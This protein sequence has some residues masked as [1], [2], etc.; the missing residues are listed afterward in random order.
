MVFQNYALYPHMTVARNMSF[1][2]ELAHAP[3]AEI[4]AQ[5]RQSGGDPRP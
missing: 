1:A 4:G 2:L 3:P 5:S